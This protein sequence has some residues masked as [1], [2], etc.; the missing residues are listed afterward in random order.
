MG[1]RSR[2]TRNG[3]PCGLLLSVQQ[4]SIA[5]YL[6]GCTNASP[7]VIIGCCPMLASVVPKGWT[8]PSDR[9]SYNT[10]GYVQQSPNQSDET[11]SKSHRLRN[12]HSS[13]SRRNRSEKTSE[14][15]SVASQ[16][17]LP[18]RRTG[19]TGIRITD[20]MRE[21]HRRRMEEAQRM[22]EERSKVHQ[23]DV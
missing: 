14:H 23:Q 22:G 18:E 1:S 20:E 19:G 6:L 11:A 12:M 3:L 17:E 8:R 2:Q 4:V 5:A 16:D 13:K 21:Q 7:A 9:A 10:Q 15:V